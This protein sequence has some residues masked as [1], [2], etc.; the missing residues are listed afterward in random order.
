MIT[1]SIFKMTYFNLKKQF[2]PIKAFNFSFPE[3][4]TLEGL[5]RILQSF[6]K[7]L[8]GKDDQWPK[9]AQW[10][11]IEIVSGYASKSQKK[12]LVI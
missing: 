5:M 1:W 8:S 11:S 12:K 4:I 10:T 2:S 6:V 7:F 3:S 9:S